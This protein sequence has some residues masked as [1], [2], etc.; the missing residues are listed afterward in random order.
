MLRVI[1]I[2]AG[3]RGKD[4]YGKYILNSDEIEIVALAEVNETKRDQARA[5]H[6]IDPALC[7]ES[8]EELLSREKFCDGVIIATPDHLHYK[9]AI[10]A[11]EKGYHILLEKPM[12]NNEDEV[13]AIA[14]AEKKSEGEVLVCHVLRYTPF[15][16][17]LKQ[18][19]RDGEIGDL[20]NIQHNENIGFYHFAHSFVRGNWRSSKES[21]PLI[22]A[23]S[24]HDMDILYWLADSPCTKVSSMGHLAY[25]KKK[26]GLHSDRCITCQIESTCPY[27]ALKLYMNSIGSWPA[28][29]ITPIQ[30]EASVYEAIKDGPYGRCVFHSDNDVVDH[31]VS[32]FEFEN[33]VHASF[34]LSAFTNDISRSLKIMGSKG[35]IKGKD[36]K[37]EIIIQPF[38]GE[39]RTIIPEQVQGGHGGGD[40]GIMND[41]VK[42]LKG[43]IHQGDTSGQTSLISHLMAFKAEESRLN[44]HVVEINYN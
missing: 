8:Y 27:S 41:F 33:G 20:I 5:Q 14:E 6:G 29:T 28:S 16:Q 43:T 38:N 44:N 30:T 24:C 34:N 13:I 18:L 40:T 25:F 17:R 15:Y 32:L 23:K 39:A 10:M 11:L 1:L 35:T 4:R 31:Q 3:D 7:F 9:P 19:I 21:S 12:S 42:L 37:N 26:E 2:G 22:L 36:S